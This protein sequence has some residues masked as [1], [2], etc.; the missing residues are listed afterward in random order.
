MP[1]GIA[2]AAVQEIMPN[3]MRGQTTAVYSLVIS[4]LGLGVA[5]TPVA[6]VTD[7]GFSDDKALR[8]SL[9]IVTSAALVF[10][11]MLLSKGLR[12]YRESLVNL[13]NWKSNIPALSTAAL[14]LR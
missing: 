8:Y 5:P 9:L 6:L 7:F 1:F 4:L 14:E 11:S 12:P 10:S 2:V 3:S 13:Q